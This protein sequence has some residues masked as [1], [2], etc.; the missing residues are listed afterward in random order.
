MLLASLYQTPGP[1]GSTVPTADLK[2]GIPQ[3]VEIPAPV[4]AMKCLED[5]ISLTR[6]STLA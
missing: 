1:V 2:S 3:D 4:K 6:S 5:R